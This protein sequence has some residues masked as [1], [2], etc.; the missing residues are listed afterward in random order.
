MGSLLWDATAMDQ[1]SYW[2]GSNRSDLPLGTPQAPILGYP[3]PIE[4]SI[5]PWCIVRRLYEG[6]HPLSRTSILNQTLFV[7]T[8]NWTTIQNAMSRLHLKFQRYLSCRMNPLQCVCKRMSTANRHIFFHL[9]T[10]TLSNS[11]QTS[12]NNVM[13]HL[14]NKY[15]ILGTPR[16]VM[17]KLVIIKTRNIA[18]LKGKYICYYQISVL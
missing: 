5:C 11:L 16:K 12:F 10:T 6:R 13:I 17:V 15:H 2:F 7:S 4:F 8:R 18:L 14:P 3:W 9:F 1:L